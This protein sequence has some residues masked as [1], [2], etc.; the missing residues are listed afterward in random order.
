[1]FHLTNISG[2]DIDQCLIVSHTLL[3]ANKPIEFGTP[4]PPTHAYY[5]LRHSNNWKLITWIIT[6][7]LIE[8][9]KRSVCININIHWNWLECSM[10]D[11]SIAFWIVKRSVTIVN[12]IL[13]ANYCYFDN[14]WIVFTYVDTN[15]IPFRERDTNVKMLK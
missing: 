13:V 1:M 10:A 3:T 7:C 15:E 6:K 14:D 9:P 8:F 4:T 12:W 11:I 5:P 2:L